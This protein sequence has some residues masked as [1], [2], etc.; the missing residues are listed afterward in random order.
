[1]RIT[2]YLSKECIKI[3]LSKTTKKKIIEELLEL[4]L[5]VNPKIN[6]E[7][8]FHC[9]IEREKVE[10]TAIGDYV[11]IPHARIKNLAKIYL[12]FGLSENG[13]DCNSIDGECVKLFFL[14]LFPEEDI[15]A[16]LKF[17]AHISRLLK[18]K[19][20]RHRLF[21]CKDYGKVID[22]FKQ[23]EEHHFQ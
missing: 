15:D 23:Y 17:L 5:S 19:N 12:A 11:A 8:A 3:P 9:L 21:K 22:A 10:T 6:K 13:I 14:I 16:Q 7:E 4:I 1:M 18:D 20:L 2:D